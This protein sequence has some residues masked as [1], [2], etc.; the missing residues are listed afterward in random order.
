[1]GSLSADLV[2]QRLVL[3]T[4]P[5]FLLV[6]Q[7]SLGALVVGQLVFAVLASFGFGAGTAMYTEMFPTRVRYT[8]V[9]MSLGVSAAI[10]GGTA[11]IVSTWL[12]SITGSRLAPGWYLVAAALISFIAVSFIAETYRSPLRAR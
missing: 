5:L 2:L 4:Y 7:G 3:A 9:G 10:F 1:M 6:S 12:V 8:G 11:P